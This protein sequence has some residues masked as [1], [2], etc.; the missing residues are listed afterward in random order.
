MQEEA[1]SD[2]AGSDSVASAQVQ[3]QAWAG[4]ARAASELVGSEV[5]P[6]ALV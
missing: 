1:A 4:Q 5:G 3:V 6:D 2:S